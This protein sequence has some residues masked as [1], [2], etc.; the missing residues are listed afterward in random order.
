MI[1]MKTDTR[2][3]IQQKA[4]GARKI[5]VHIEELVLHGFGPERRWNIGDAVETELR[6]LLAEKGIPGAWLSN[7]ER[8]E[9]GAIA[10]TGPTRPAAIGTQ[11]AGAV[12]RGGA[13]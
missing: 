2:K 1:A 6:G 8:I 10:A 11:I 9:A 3:T 5:D 4:T 7:P 12:Y 13:R